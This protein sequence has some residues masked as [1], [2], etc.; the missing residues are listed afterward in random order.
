ML[1]EILKDRNMSIY[2]LAKLSGIPYATCNDIVSGKARLEKCSAETVYRISNVLGVSMEEMLSPYL[3]RRGS[4]E[5][6][7][8]SVC[9]RVKDMGDLDFIVDVLESDEIRTLFKRKWYPEALYLLGMLDYI[10]RENQI[11]ICNDYDDLRQYKLSE[12]LFPASILALAAAAQDDLVL[13]D[14]AT[15]AIPEFKRFNI[16]ENEVRNVV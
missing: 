8:S 6:F 5:N 14:A 10:S 7:K 12:P 15:S 1:R 9:H 4:F 2:R 11:S 13:E 16:I 3:V